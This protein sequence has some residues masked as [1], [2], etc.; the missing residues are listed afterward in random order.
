MQSMKESYDVVVIGSGFGGAI[1]A[2]RNAEAGRSVAILE[3][4]RRWPKEAF[5]RTVGQ[6]SGAFWRD[7]GPRGFLEYRAFKKIDVLQ[8]VGVGGG[9]LHYFNV[10]L[11]APARVLDRW[12]RPLSRS[13]LEPY[14]DRARERLDSRPLSPPAGRTLP[15]RTQAFQRAVRAAG[16]G[17]PVLTD[18]AVYTGPDRQNWAGVAQSACVYCGNCMLGCHVH[19]KNSLDITY[20]ADGE[21]RYGV[22]VFALHQVRAIR[23]AVDRGEGYWVD[24]RVSPDESVNGA[25][26]GA[27]ARDSDGRV[28]GK[29]VIV[30]AGTL[31]SNELLL[32]CRDE[33][34]SL[35]RLSRALGTRFSGN[36]DMLFA[37]AMG[38][39]AAI[40]PSLGPSITAIVD[41]S[42][43]E[44]AIH[45]EDLGYADPMMWLLEGALPPTGGRVLGGL[46]LLGRYLARALGIGTRGSRVTERLGTLLEGGRTNHFL[47]YLGMGDDAADGRMR[48]RGGELDIVWSHRRSR[49]MFS[50]MEDA[51][52]RISTAAGG[53]YTPSFLWRWPMRKLLTAHPLGGCVMSD[54]EADGVVSHQGEV[55]NYP[56]LYVTDGAS[57]PSGLSVNPSLTIAAVAERAS[58]W[59]LH[60]RER[61]AADK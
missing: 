32:R 21:R 13:T 43:P 10:N 22:E 52:R 23:P 11:P 3:Q 50:Q 30:A 45:V 20:I 1:T 27:P 51:M 2:Y 40:D 19:A 56:G 12:P 9:S 33:L 61:T 58:Q 47:P 25:G 57:L 48:L 37:G 36:G 59:M 53:K 49:A 60:G 35:P 14:Y 16:L 17:E 5:P 24:F 8:G 29:K 34:G 55:W 6:T 31:G 38:T 28:H 15:P 41:C 44:H 46:R 26:S 54:S 42:T 4:G 18:I 39:P 7:E